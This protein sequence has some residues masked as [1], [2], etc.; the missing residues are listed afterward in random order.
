MPKAL[1]IP[2]VLLV[3]VLFF[4]YYWTAVRNWH[5]V[6]VPSYETEA[7]DLL[8]GKTPAAWADDPTFR[9]E[10]LRHLDRTFYQPTAEG[11]ALPD[12]T[13][14]EPG[15]VIEE[16]HFAALIEARRTTV[17]LRN[18]TAIRAMA[19]RNYRLRNPLPAVGH[20]AGTRLTKPVIDD[21]VAAGLDR[22]AV[23]GAGEMI[24][25][26]F[27]TM[28]MVILIFLGLVAA[29]Q[30]ALWDPVLGLIDERRRLVEEG[31]TLARA[32]RSDAT[33]VE[34]EG[35]GLLADVRREYLRDLTATQREA[36]KEAD[37]ILHAAREE[38]QA[39]RH[40]AM[41]DLEQEVARAADELETKRDA[42][43]REI[44][45]AV[46]GRKPAESR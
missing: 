7:V 30:G 9:R 36:G 45:A 25:V 26:Q 16:Q 2:I 6:T 41:Q 23:V 13:R 37:R 32:N 18:P 11:L 27:G 29:L 17:T 10:H 28:L 38:A 40:E 39:L 8:G 21:L 14:L 42:I 12:G 3:A 15:A 44:A 1:R 35:H 33:E 31:E 5:L 46:L 19:K 20:E 4:G 24:S 34:E 22:V 43:A